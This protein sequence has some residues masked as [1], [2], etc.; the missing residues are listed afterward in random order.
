[1]YKRVSER[2]R[3]R[4][5]IWKQRDSRRDSIEWGGKDCHFCVGGALKQ[6][7]LDFRHQMTFTQTRLS[8]CHENVVSANHSDK[9]QKVVRK[10]LGGVATDSQDEIKEHPL[11]SSAS[12][13]WQFTEQN[14]AYEVSSY[15]LLLLCK[16]TYYSH[17]KVL[18]FQVSTL[19]P[20]TPSGWIHVLHLCSCKPH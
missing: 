5:E 19:Y 12:L 20:A 2:E 7:F 11:A 14:R 13:P 18:H 17:V 3:E 10:A 16:S 4:F 15:F 6:V 1:M 8:C 9:M